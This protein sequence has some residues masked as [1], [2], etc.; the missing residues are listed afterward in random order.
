MG[1]MFKLQSK[2]MWLSFGT[3]FVAWLIWCNAQVNQGVKFEWSSHDG[4]RQIDSCPH[5]SGMS[6][7]ITAPF[8]FLVGLQSKRFIAKGFERRGWGEARGTLAVDHIVFT[9][10]VLGVS[11]QHF[12]IV[13]PTVTD[14]MEA[15]KEGNTLQ[16]Q[17]LLD[18]GARVNARDQ[19]GRTALMY[20]CM[21][22]V[23]SPELLNVLFLRGADVNSISNDGSTAL[24]VATGDGVRVVCVKNLITYGANVNIMDRQGNAPLILAIAHATNDSDANLAVE[25]LLAAGAD[26]RARNHVGE[27]PIL[28]AKKLDRGSVIQILN[29]AGVQ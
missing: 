14:L 13:D 9:P 19:D 22:S 10:I 6:R 15:A 16:V 7:V 5:T 21:N 18:Q 26:P 4:F 24:H 20:A 2:G 17:R 3:I 8:C 28:C 1:K 25:L 27:T 23:V 11:L 29:R 12:S